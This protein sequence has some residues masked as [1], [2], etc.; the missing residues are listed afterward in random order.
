MTETGI[1]LISM[2]DVARLARRAAQRSETGSPAIRRTSPRSEAVVRA[3]RCTTR[4]RSSTGSG[5][6]TASISVRKKL[7]P[8]GNSRINSEAT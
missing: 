1:D 4:L 5:R 8:S 3:A 6:P 7:L 2:A